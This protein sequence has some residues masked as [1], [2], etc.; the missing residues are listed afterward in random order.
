VQ[1]TETVP[2]PRGNASAGKAAEE[3]SAV[4]AADTAEADLRMPPKLPYDDGAFLA[5]HLIRKMS[6]T[7]FDKMLRILNE[8]QEQRADLVESDG[9]AV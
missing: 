2:E 8:H 9:Q 1:R 4:D 6:D 7:E 5:M 3:V